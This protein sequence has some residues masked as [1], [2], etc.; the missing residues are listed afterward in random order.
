MI[1]IT[2]D[3]AGWLADFAFDADYPWHAE[4]FPPGLCQQAVGQPIFH[5]LLRGKLLIWCWILALMVWKLFKDIKN[6]VHFKRLMVIGSLPLLQHNR[7]SH[8][9]N[10]FQA[11]Y[12]HTCHRH[13][14]GWLRPATTTWS[15]WWRERRLEGSHE[16]PQIYLDSIKDQDLKLLSW[17][18]EKEHREAKDSGLTPSIES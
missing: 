18:Q 1:I 11:S 8:L 5:S 10:P 12:P 3:D 14:F 4:R 16:P 6:I 7:F 15:V 17:I 2:S 9:Y 13:S